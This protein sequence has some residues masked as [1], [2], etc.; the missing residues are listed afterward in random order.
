MFRHLRAILGERL[1]PREYVK[2]CRT[3]I[4]NK[5]IDKT[6]CTVLGFMH[7]PA[8]HGTNIKLLYYVLIIQYFNMIRNKY[9]NY[10]LQNLSSE[11]IVLKFYYKIVKSLY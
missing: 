9:K 7:N 11:H 6:Q 8:M 2:T 10:V 1:C 4:S 5:Y 3:R